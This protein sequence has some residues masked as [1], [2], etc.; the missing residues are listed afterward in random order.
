[1]K[2]IILGAVL[3]VGVILGSACSSDSTNPVGA[4]QGGVPVSTRG[5][6]SKPTLKPDRPRPQVQSRPAGKGLD[7]VLRIRGD[8]PNGISGLFLGVKNVRVFAGQQE[9]PVSN[10]HDPVIDLANDANA[11][12]LGQFNVPPG[13]QSVR[14]E[15]QVDDYGG[16]ETAG[17]AGTVNAR[18]APITF[19]A[20]LDDLAL[21]GHAV[22]HMNVD[23]SL[24]DTGNGERLL[25]PKVTVR[26]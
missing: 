23:Q 14:V 1:M 16:F 18:T 11:W 19:E 25:L 20:A 17:K 3:G 21:H 9:L 4:K 13:V 7:A 12:G 15:L 5:P 22:V 2:R 26:Y 6:T 24:F 8:N 10:P